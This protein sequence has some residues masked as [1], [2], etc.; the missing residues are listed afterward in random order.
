MKKTIAVCL[1]AGILVLVSL[2]SFGQQAYYKT[3]AWVSEKGY[4]VAENN[5]RTPRHCILRFYSNDNILVGTKEFSGSRLKL[6]RRKTKMQ[7]KRM[8][9]AELLQWAASQNA[10]DSQL[11]KHP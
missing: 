9:E 8:L 4:W 5:L 3:P 2:N 10:I 1:A 11:V 6:N 7:L